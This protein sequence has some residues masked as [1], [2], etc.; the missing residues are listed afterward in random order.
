[1]EDKKLLKDQLLNSLPPQWPQD[2][3]PAIQKHIK[4]DGRK[5]VVLDD[6][7]TGTQTVHGLPVLTEWSLEQ[8]VAELQNELPAFYILTNSRSLTPPEARKINAEIG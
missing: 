1:M 3:R 6:D 2:L 8:L 7:P 4:A 5:V